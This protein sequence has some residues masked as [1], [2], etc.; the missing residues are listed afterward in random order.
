MKNN[1]E[2]LYLSKM[3]AKTINEAAK[4]YAKEQLGE[5]QFKKNKDAVKSICEDFKAG[6]EFAKKELNGLFVTNGQ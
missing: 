6:A 1:I 5:D 3:D 4:S 2:K